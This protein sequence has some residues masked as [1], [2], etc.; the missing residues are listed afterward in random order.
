MRYIFHALLFLVVT[1]GYSNV[2]SAKDRS[3]KY[4]DPNFSILT[5]FVGQTDLLD[6]K[7]QKVFHDYLRATE[8][9]IYKSAKNSQFMLQEIQQDVLK[10]FATNREKMLYVRVPITFDV[11]NYNFDTQS[12]S[13]LPHNQLKKT[14]LFQILP[15]RFEV[16]DPHNNVRFTGIPMIYYSKMM[17]PV[18]LYRIPLQRDVAEAL[19]PRLDKRSIRDENTRVIY[20]YLHLQLEPLMPDVQ[21]TDLYYTALIHGQLNAIDLYVDYDRKILL[22]RLVYDE[23]F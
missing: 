22:K 9:D 5:S 11:S 2:S 19:F 12:F 1:V 15:D 16:C 21:K 20:G 17:A 23:G 18:S 6:L 8:C 7:D 14:N 13:I 4:I 10:G 3:S